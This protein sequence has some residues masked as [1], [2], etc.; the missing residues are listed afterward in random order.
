MP[1]PVGTAE[2]SAVALGSQYE[3]GCDFAMLLQGAGDSLSGL[4]LPDTW[5][6]SL[7]PKKSIVL[8]H[9]GLSLSK[10]QKVQN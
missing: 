7:P 9:R 2:P 8:E 1:G 3:K 6:E 4:V 5:P 10:S